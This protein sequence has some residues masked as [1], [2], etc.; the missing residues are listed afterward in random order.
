MACQEAK[1]KEMTRYCN[2]KV[3]H[4]FKKQ[5]INH[6]GDL[7]ILDRGKRFR[8]CEAFLIKKAGKQ[9]RKI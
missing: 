2:L 3:N 6:Y 9:D 4:G 1:F 7:E 8:F 5:F